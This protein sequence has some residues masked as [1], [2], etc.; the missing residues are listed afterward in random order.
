ML[1]THNT[2]NANIVFVKANTA[3]AEEKTK[4]KWV[5]FPSLLL[6]ILCL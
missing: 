3:S 5:H 1:K 2:I 4:E 6:I